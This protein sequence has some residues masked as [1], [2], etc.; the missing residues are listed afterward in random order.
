[1]ILFIFR[2]KSALLQQFLLLYET[3]DYNQITIILHA[4]ENNYISHE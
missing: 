1:M 3:F 2:D 4:E